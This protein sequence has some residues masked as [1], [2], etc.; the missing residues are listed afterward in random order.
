M[1]EF[2]VRK[3]ASKH[4]SHWAKIYH[5]SQDLRWIAYIE[6]YAFALA[7][8]W[9]QDSK[10]PCFATLDGKYIV[11]DNGLVNQIEWIDETPEEVFER[12]YTAY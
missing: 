7:Q 1:D 6:K 9:V 11:F 4:A 8:P 2:T 12:I 10:Y 5:D 3:L